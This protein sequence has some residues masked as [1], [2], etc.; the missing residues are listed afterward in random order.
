MTTTSTPYRIHNRY[1]IKIGGVEVGF[2]H[3]GANREWYA[4]T[5]ERKM[6][7]YPVGYLDILTGTGHRTQRAAADAL[8]AKLSGMHA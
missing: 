3:R 8:I 5:V 7:A 4:C 6:D 2:L 1:S